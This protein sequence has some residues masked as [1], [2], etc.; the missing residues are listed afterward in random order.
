MGGKITGKYFGIRTSGREYKS[1]FSKE[2]VNPYKELQHGGIMFGAFGHNV[3]I[4]DDDYFY[5]WCE[6]IV[7]LV[8]R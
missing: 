4:S 6:K 1:A 3:W 5:P 7:N 2:I 8:M